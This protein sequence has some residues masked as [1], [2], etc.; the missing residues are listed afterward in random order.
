MTKKNYNS[1]RNS[2]YNSYYKGFDK[3]GLIDYN[4]R[5]LEKFVLVDNEFYN[6]LLV[7][8]Y[9]ITDKQL[10]KLKIIY[11]QQNK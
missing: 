9:K 6:S 11:K 10:N 8:E 5:V 2:L 4:K 1:K 3:G 7:Q